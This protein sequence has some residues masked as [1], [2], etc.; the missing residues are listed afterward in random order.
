MALHLVAADYSGMAGVLQVRNLQ[1]DLN[2]ASEKEDWEMTRR[3]DKTCGS[4]VDK[5]I[6]ASK[7]DSV[8]Q[9]DSEALILALRDL[10][11]IYAGLIKKCHHEVAAMGR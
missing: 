6:A 11:E 4:L 7:V 9:E 8:N 5:V 1:L 3:L 10:K 2:I